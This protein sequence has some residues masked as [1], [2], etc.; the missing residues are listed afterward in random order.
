M[1]L[2]RIVLFNACVVKLQW[3]ITCVKLSFSIN[4]FKLSIAIVYS[5]W[6]KYRVLYPLFTLSLIERTTT[7][8]GYMQMS[9][10]CT[11]FL[12]TFNASYCCYVIPSPKRYMKLSFYTTC[13]SVFRQTIDEWQVGMSLHHCVSNTKKSSEEVPLNHLV[14]Y[15]IHDM[16][17]RKCYLYEGMVTNENKKWALAP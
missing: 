9:R 15:S 16:H 10:K 13:W 8:L 1:Q 3:N 4:A 2:V 11:Q 14:L 5:M 7:V 17:A 12:V 6:Y